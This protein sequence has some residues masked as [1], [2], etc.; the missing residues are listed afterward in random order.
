MR[1]VAFD[2]RRLPIPQPSNVLPAAVSSIIESCFGPAEQRPSFDGLHGLLSAALLAAV[3]EETPYP[4]AF[5]CPIGLEVMR[6]PVICSDG[7]SYE[8]ENIERWLRNCRR[9]PKTNETLRSG[10][11]VVNHALRAAIEGFVVPT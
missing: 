4:D 9:S 5:L 10:R 2:N 7:H 8:R 11:I 1:Q 6:D 3:H